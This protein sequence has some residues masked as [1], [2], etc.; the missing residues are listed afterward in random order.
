MFTISCPQKPCPASS[1]RLMPLAFF[2]EF[3]PSHTWSSSSS[4]AFYFFPE[5]LSFSIEFCL[6]M[7]CSEVGQLEFCRF[8]SSNV[9]DLICSRTYLF[10]FLVVQDSCKALFQHHIV[11]EST[12]ILL[13]QPS[14]LSNFHFYT[15]VI[16]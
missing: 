7:M 16:V 3:K 14:S 5:L 4:S 15:I 11:N 6:L 9:S 10:I 8:A 1:Y 2:Y 13:L 12:N